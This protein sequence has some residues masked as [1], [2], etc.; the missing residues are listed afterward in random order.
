[1][2]IPLHSERS[3]EYGLANDV[4]GDIVLNFLP[5]KASTQMPLETA[6]QSSLPS[7]VSVVKCVAGNPFQVSACQSEHACGAVCV[8]LQS[9][10]K[11]LI[12]T[13][14]PGSRVLAEQ[15]LNL[16]CVECDLHHK[17]HSDT[18]LSKANMQAL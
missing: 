10:E 6:H 18:E 3:D 11:T 5:S 7:A 8:F 15:N 2:S 16:G 14:A 9:N 13:F 1:L 17:S 4:L 12:T